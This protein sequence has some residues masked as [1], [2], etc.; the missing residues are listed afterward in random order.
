[1]STPGVGRIYE[2]FG[3][4]ALPAEDALRREG[5]LRGLNEIDTPRHEIPRRTWNDER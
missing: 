1:M 2:D 5:H 3:E 4:D